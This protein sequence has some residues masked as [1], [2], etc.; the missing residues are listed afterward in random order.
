MKSVLFSMLIFSVLAGNV[1]PDAVRLCIPVWRSSGAEAKLTAGLLS[2]K[3]TFLPLFRVSN[4]SAVPAGDWIEVTKWRLLIE[5]EPEASAAF[6]VGPERHEMPNRTLLRVTV[7]K[8][9]AIAVPSDSAE[10]DC[11]ARSGH[12]FRIAENRIYGPGP[13]GNF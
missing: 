5:L 3:N 12:C 7:V 8:Q 9:K 1:P 13:A 2:S 6:A 10:V 11:H 4:Q